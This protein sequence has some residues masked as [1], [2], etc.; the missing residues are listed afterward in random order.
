VQGFAKVFLLFPSPPQ[1][2][3][4]ER[5]GSGAGKPPP[6]NTLF[7]YSG[8]GLLPIRATFEKLYMEVIE[9]NNK[10]RKKKVYLLETEANNARAHN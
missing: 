1:K 7:N 10:E 6:P 8:V 5:V 4:K 2:R 3:V 9:W